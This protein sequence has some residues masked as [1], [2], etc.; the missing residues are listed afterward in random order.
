MKRRLALAVGL[1]L[2]VGIAAVAA[3]KASLHFARK[4]TRCDLATAYCSLVPAVT[5]TPAIEPIPA[6]G[7][8]VTAYCWALTLF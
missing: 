2:G 8:M 4:Y 5:V 6:G 1:G 7:R 3:A